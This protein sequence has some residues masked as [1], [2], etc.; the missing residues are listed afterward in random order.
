MN[1]F[2]ELLI[3]GLIKIKNKTKRSCIIQELKN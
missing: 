2:R 3:M 1:I